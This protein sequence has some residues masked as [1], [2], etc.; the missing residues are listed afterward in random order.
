MHVR[1]NNGARS[2]TIFEVKKQKYI[3]RLNQLPSDWAAEHAEK[4]GIVCE[5]TRSFT[6][7]STHYEMR[8]SCGTYFPYLKAQTM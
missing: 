4:V 2:G 5:D 3:A 1:Q 7:M 6:D 8:R